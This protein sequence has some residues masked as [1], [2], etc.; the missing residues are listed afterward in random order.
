MDGKTIQP[1]SDKRRPGEVLDDTPEK[2]EFD[3]RHLVRVY[4]KQV[5]ALMKNFTEFIKQWE[6]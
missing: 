3:L 4:P 6:D 5:D 2:I 1:G